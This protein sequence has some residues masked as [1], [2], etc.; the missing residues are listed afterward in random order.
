MLC[1]FPSKQTLLLDK[2]CFCWPKKHVL[3][4]WIRD[5]AHTATLWCL[6]VVYMKVHI[7]VYVHV[8]PY[9]SRAVSC[10]C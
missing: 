4:H 2:N 3:L 1:L 10:Y 8:H 7:I 9:V 5:K 6:T